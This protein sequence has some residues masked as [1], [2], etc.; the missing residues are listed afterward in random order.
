VDDSQHTPCLMEKAT[1]AGM[2][3]GQLNRA[4]LIEGR[5]MCWQALGKTGL[6]PKR[7]N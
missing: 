2:V 5:E 3:E 7:K 1:I 4:L 6:L